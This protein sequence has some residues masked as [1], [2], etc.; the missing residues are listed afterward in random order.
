MLSPVSGGF[1]VISQ[2]S[3][4]YPTRALTHFSFCQLFCFRLS[5]LPSFDAIKCSCCLIGGQGG[6]SSQGQRGGNLGNPNTSVKHSVIGDNSRRMSSVSRGRCLRMGAAPARYTVPFC[7]ECSLS[8]SPFQG[9]HPK[10]LSGLTRGLA[11]SMCLEE[12]GAPNQGVLRFKA[13]GCRKILLPFPKLPGIGGAS[14]Q[15]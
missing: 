11:R 12:G 2:A 3:L 7:Q 14:L 6:S 8:S 10:L 5:I 1:N 13:A 15:S 4:L 9:L